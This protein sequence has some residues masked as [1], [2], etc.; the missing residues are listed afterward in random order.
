MPHVCQDDPMTIP[1]LDHVHRMWASDAASRALGI[2]LVDVGVRDGL[3]YAH[4]RMTVTEAQVNGHDIQHG[5]Y[6]F[7]LADSTFALACNA[8][9]EL[10][11][12]SGADIGF[13]AAGRLGDVLVAR[14]E[15]R[16]RYGRSGITDV[17]VI[18]E[19]DGA[20]IAEF[21]GRSRTLGQQGGG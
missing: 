20:R 14:A 15:E 3:G 18:R 2:E 17:T 19:A 12:A 4:T 9:G 8:S 21:R 6:I 1:N 7:T 11:V 5:G 16:V 13:I 10:T